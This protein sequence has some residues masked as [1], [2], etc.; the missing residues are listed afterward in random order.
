MRTYVAT[1]AN[2]DAPLAR[3]RRRGQGSRAHRHCRGQDASGQAQGDLHAVPRHRGPRRDRERRQGQADRPQG[4]SEDLPPP[5]GYE[6]GLREERAKVVRSRQPARLVE[7]AVRGMLPKTT[8]GD[9]MYGKLK[10]YAG[11]THP[12]CGAATGFVRGRHNLAALQYYATGRR[13]T[14]TARVFLRPGTGAITVNRREFA[15]FFPTESLRIAVKTPLIPHRDRR[16]VRRAVHGRRRRRGRSGRRHS[17][18]HLARAVRVRPRA[19]QQVEEGRA[20]DAR[21][22]SQGT[23]EI[24]SGR[25]P[26]AVPVQQAVTTDGWR[27]LGPTRDEGPARGRCAL[28]SPDEALEP[29]DEAVYLR[30][31]QRHL[32]SRPRQDGQA[33]PRGG[34]LRSSARRRRQ[35]HPVRRHQAAGAGRHRRRSRALRDVLRQR[36]LA[37]RPADQLLH[38]PA[39]HRASPRSRSHGHRRPLR[40]R[41]RRRRS[42]KAEKEKKQAAE[43]PR[44]HPQ[45]VAAARRALRGRHPEG[46]D[47]RRRGAQAEDSGDRHR[48]HQLRPR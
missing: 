20:P 39:Q 34:G 24:R 26:Q 38:H 35:D 30:R 36:A 46:K 19:A 10:V 8:L 12:A 48:R 21:R 41:C 17:P 9:A 29:E 6:G 11:A 22:A 47:C 33:V 44:R 40:G 7:E 14:S 42:R 27:T 28:R 45:H 23:Q 31:T 5:L 13:K 1:P 32:H 37:G 15:E 3:D 25:S 16:E 2:G 18:R 4:R 43:E